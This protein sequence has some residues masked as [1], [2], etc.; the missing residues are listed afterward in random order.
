MSLSERLAHAQGEMA[1]LGCELALFGSGADLLY[2]TGYEAM[3][4]ERLTMLV[5][6]AE[7][8][9][10]LFVPE[11]EAP[12]VGEGPFRLRP[13]KE[14]DDP[15]A[16]VADL[17][18]SPATAAVSDQLWALF[19]LALQERL[20]RT[21]FISATAITRPLRVRKQPAELERLRSASRAAD[22][23]VERLR[24]ERFGGRS[25]R[26]LSRL[27]VD[28]TV[29]EG[30]DQAAFWIVASGPNGASPH[31]EPGPRVIEQGDLV[32]V[33]FGGKV[34][35]YGSDC[36]RT[37]AV[38]SP[39]QEQEEVHAVVLAAQ[40]AGMATVAPVVAAED[41][42]REARQVITEAGYGEYFIHRTGHGIG[43]EG[44]EHPYLVEGNRELLEAGMCFSIE[45]GIY[46][47]GRFGV[48]IEDIVTV[49]THGVEALNQA[50]R[51]LQ[52]VS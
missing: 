29:E 30:H 4:L 7:G 43:L 27:I 33:D 45:P 16:L 35:G 42:D 2:L 11:L 52:V 36:T 48:R 49:T 10:T 15:I 25:E 5:V 34:G 40:Q 41:V 44:H 26:E 47:P 17:V 31:H 3:P 6:P 22:R 23:V 32:V 14:T 38:G 51:S 18:G 19:L 46:L 28:L 9:A 39:T 1:A 24:Q 50:D 13:W 8:E 37:F 20:P 21:R 12:R